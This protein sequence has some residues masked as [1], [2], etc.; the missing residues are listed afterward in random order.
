[1]LLKVFLDVLLDKVY[2]WKGTQEKPGEVNG[3][4]TSVTTSSEFSTG[5]TLANDKEIHIYILD[6]T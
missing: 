5:V 3:T 1:M 2:G 6:C 4:K